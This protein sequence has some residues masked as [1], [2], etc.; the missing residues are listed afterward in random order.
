VGT[1]SGWGA[2]P[3]ARSRQVDRP[4]RRLRARSQHWRA[5]LERKRHLPAGK[6]FPDSDSA[7]AAPRRPHE[8]RAVGS[9]I[10]AR[11]DLC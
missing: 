1:V 7:A 10:M 2:S 6:T 5:A 3:I 9:A 4:L 11:R 8:P